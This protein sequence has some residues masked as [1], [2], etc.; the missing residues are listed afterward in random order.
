M[1]A[2]L[3]H[4]AAPPRLARQI[5][6]LALAALANPYTLFGRDPGHYW[7]AAFALPLLLAGLWV[8]FGPVAAGARLP[9]LARLSRELTLL[10]LI[11]QWA[12]V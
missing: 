4:D 5:A 12:D 2:A 11:L 9:R 8:L 6:L 7:L 1:L 3:D 10:V